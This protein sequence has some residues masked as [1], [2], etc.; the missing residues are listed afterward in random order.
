[1]QM[2][3]KRWKK[4]KS[5]LEKEEEE[6]KREQETLDVKEHNSRQRAD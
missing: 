4:V 2:R 5:H 6:E 3:K 1:M